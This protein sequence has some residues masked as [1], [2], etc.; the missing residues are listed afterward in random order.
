MMQSS[1][2][3][4]YQAVHGRY[5]RGPAAVDLFPPVKHVLGEQ[6]AAAVAQVSSAQEVIQ[7]GTAQGRVAWGRVEVGGNV[8][9]DVLEHTAAIGVG[10]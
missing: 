4:R 6:E 8:V 3:Y 5:D 9:K 7:H 10:G 1:P 2:L